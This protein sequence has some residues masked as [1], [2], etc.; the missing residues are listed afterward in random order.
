[1]WSPN[2][3][4]VIKWY[5][6]DS[7]EQG[8]EMRGLLSQVDD[9]TGRHCVDENAYTWHKVE[10]SL[11]QEQWQGVCAHSCSAPVTVYTW[12]EVQQKEWRTDGKA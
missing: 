7:D 3:I 4:C 9:E 8:P 2:V 6:K 1:M 10:W 12:T 11:W 5:N